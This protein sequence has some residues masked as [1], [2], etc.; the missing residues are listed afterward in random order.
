MLY[1]PGSVLGAGGGAGGRAGGA[2]SEAGAGGAAG[3]LKEVSL[4]LVF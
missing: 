1:N 3:I 4:S 2:A